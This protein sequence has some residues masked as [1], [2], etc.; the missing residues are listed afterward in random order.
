MYVNKDRVKE[1]T[2]YM[3]K[4][5]LEWVTS[6]VN[7]KIAVQTDE[8]ARFSFH[9]FLYDNNLVVDEMERGSDLWIACPFHDDASPSC[10]INEEKYIYHC[11]SCGS[12]GN[13]INLIVDYKNKFEDSGTGYYRVLNSFLQNDKV[14]Q[15][16]LGYDSIYVNQ[17]EDKFD[18]NE[19]LQKFRFDPP[20][21][22]VY[23]SS[24]C[25]LADLLIKR[26]ATINQIKLFIILMQEE[27][28][29]REIYNELYDEGLDDNDN[30]NN[31]AETI[32]LESLMA[33]D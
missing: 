10:S 7:T 30:D 13:L 28:S 25:E 14:M 21:G 2:D 11:F 31:T 12:K 8:R 26:K 15:A 1:A 29:V 23:P 32:S 19:A 4:V 17:A 3:K 27:V 33:F 16:E 5:N 9:K 18:F 22:F 24:Y 20:K 6:G